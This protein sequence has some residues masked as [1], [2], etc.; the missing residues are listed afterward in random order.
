M[1]EAR[2]LIFLP[3]FFGFGFSKPPYLSIHARLK[4]FWAVNIWKK[5]FYTNI[6]PS[7]RKNID[8]LFRDYSLK[9]SFGT[10]FSLSP[11]FL[12][13]SVYVYSVID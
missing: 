2:S 3:F 12:Q 4:I 8:F 6:A 11:D 7:G 1:L 9:N 5:C 13:L 10:L